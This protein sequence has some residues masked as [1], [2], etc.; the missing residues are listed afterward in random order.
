MSKSID[1]L[2]ED[3]YQLFEG[4]ECDSTLAKEFGKELSEVVTNRLLHSGDSSRPTLRMSNIGRPCDRQLYYDVNEYDK[5]P[6]LPHTKLKF[7]LGDIVE[8]VLLYLAKEAGHTVEQEQAEVTVNGIKGHIDAVID[9]VVVDVKSASSYAYKKFKDGTLPE[10]DSF[11]YIAQIAGYR[12]ALGLDRSAFLAMDKQNGNICVY[13]PPHMTNVEERIEHIKEVVE[14]EV[15][16]PRTFEPVPLSKTDKSGN[17]KLG[18]ECSY[19]GHKYSCWEDLRTFAY[20]Y[21]P[22]YMPHVEKEPR[23]PEIFKDGGDSDAG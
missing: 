22:V 4:H 21:G 7:L 9:G 12:H 17:L 15:P 8:S 11:G 5:E 23:V 16:P 6:L 13:E 10:Q 20:S 18:T 19:C 2:V 3:I 14:Y 1:T